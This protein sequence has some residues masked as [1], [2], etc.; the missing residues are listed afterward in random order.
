MVKSCCWRRIYY[1]LWNC[2]PSTLDIFTRAD[3]PNIFAILHLTGRWSPFRKREIVN[4]NCIKLKLINCKTE[5]WEYW[6]VSGMA[7]RSHTSSILPQTSF[8]A[9]RHLWSCLLPTNGSSPSAGLSTTGWPSTL[10]HPLPDQSDYSYLQSYSPFS[11]TSQNTLRHK[12]L[13]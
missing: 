11:S 2:D 6:F 3:A 12:L 1:G 5:S 4:S 9:C 7:T 8:C 13:W 10:S